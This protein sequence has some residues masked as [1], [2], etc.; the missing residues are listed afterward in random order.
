MN[1][2]TICSSHQQTSPLNKTAKGLNLSIFI[3]QW[4]KI[5]DIRVQNAKIRFR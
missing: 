2:T 4:P 3:L 5:Y 1:P